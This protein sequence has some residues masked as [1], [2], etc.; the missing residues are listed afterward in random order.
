MNFLKCN[1]CYKSTTKIY[2]IAYT[3]LCLCKKTIRFLNKYN[4]SIPVFNFS[5]LI[6]IYTLNRIRFDDDFLKSK[7][8]L[9]KHIIV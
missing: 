2:F 6:L 1:T 7:L 5:Y 8:V 3:N 4:R 9:T